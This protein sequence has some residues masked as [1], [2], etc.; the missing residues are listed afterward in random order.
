M[1]RRL[2]LTQHAPVQDVATARYDTSLETQ[3]LSEVLGG[4]TITTVFATL[5]HGQ[6]DRSSATLN[7]ARNLA[8]VKVR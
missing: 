1:P 8:S 4:N 2:H 6:P 7:I 5:R 3:L